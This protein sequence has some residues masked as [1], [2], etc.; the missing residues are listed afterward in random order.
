MKQSNHL[1]EAFP[2][3]LAQLNTSRKSD[4]LLEEICCDL[5]RLSVDLELARNETGRMSEGLR[6]DVIASIN[7]LKQEILNRLGSNS[8]APV[9]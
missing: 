6:Q 9:E 1:K 3:C 2:D 7:A 4:P 8:E 5:E